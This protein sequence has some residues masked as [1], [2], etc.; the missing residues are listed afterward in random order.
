MGLDNYS[1]PSVTRTPDTTVDHN[2]YTQRP[3]IDNRS[4]YSLHSA[5]TALVALIDLATPHP[6]P[7][8]SNTV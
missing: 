2:T 6:L 5:T 1:Q 7:E 8:F 3:S 4:Q